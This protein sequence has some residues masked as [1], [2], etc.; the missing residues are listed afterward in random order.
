MFRHL[1]FV[2]STA[3]LLAG[4]AAAESATPKLH[5]VEKACVTYD[6]GGQMQSGTL[7]RCHRDFAYET[8]EIQNVSIGFGGFSQ[9]QTSHTITVG[10]TI[11]NVDTKAKTATKTDN[12]MYDS[13]V[14]ALQN[15]SAEDMGSAFLDAMGMTS[16]GTTKTVAGETCTVYSSQMMG[17]AC[18]SSDWLMLEQTVMGMTQT[19]TSVS[20][21]TGGDDANYTLYQTVSVSNGPDLSNLPGG[22]A[23][24]FGN[25]N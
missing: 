4:P 6:L 13:L 9:T 10:D 3:A 25:G 23:G 20:R 24:I 21:D 2:C 7:T 17:Q 18:L 22:L 8:Y 12:P 15:S 16:T 5:P 19:A 1:M 11:Y 14:S